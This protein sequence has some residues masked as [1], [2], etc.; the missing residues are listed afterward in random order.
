MND[1]QLLF[2][3]KL[4][5]SVRADLM[6]EIDEGRRNLHASQELGDQVDMAAEVEQHQLTI[7]LIE[8]KTKLLHNVENSLQLIEDGEYGYDMQTGEPIGLERLL[9]RP[10]ATL[11]ISSKEVQE[12]KER[13]EEGD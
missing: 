9:A 2:F 5:Q 13:T 8:R 3:K 4:L 11:C 7:R 6:R 1:S 12:I 10:T